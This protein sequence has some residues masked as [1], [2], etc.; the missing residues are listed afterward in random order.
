PGAPPP[1]FPENSIV[2]TRY[3]VSNFGF[4][5]PEA[6]LGEIITPGGPTYRVVGVIEDYR[7]SGGL[8]DPLRSTSILRATQDPLRV[9][10]LRIDPA[11][12]DEALEHIDEVWARHRPD[13]P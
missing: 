7:Q 3:A 10:L 5:S 1:T 13:V 4:A 11:Q 9:L 8:E 12:M 6:A 2:I